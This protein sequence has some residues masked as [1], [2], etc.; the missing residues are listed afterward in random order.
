MAATKHKVTIKGTKDGLLFYMDDTCSFDELIHELKE[1]MENSH[2]RF[3]SGPLMKITIKIGYRYLTAEQEDILRETIR[4]KGN[5]IIESIDS[6]VIT[7]EEALLEKLASQVKI[8]TR[9]VRSGQVLEQTGDLLLLGDVNPGGT[10]RCSGNIFVMARCGD[11]SCGNGGRRRCDYCR[12]AL[13][14]D[15]A[16]HRRRG[17]PTAG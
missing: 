8:E 5:L 17:E 15:P 6:N 14:A 1:K 13:S 3:L 12:F 16:S 11:G 9:T 2:Q 4:S 7:K 10:V